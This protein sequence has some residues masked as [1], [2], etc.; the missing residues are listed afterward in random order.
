MISSDIQAAEAAQKLQNFK[1]LLGNPAWTEGL[2]PKLQEKLTEATDGLRAR[3]K[4]PEQRAEWMEAHFILE[5]LIK[6]P[7]QEAERLRKEVND[8]SRAA[9]NVTTFQQSE[10]LS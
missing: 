8:W 3:N 6:Y 2:L 9:N 1:A 5:E 7:S 4:T 10:A